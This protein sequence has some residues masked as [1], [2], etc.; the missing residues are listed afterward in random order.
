MYSYGGKLYEKNGSLSSA[1]KR[2]KPL[3]TNEPIIKPISPQKVW[4]ISEC[5]F[6]GED[7]IVAICASGKIAEQQLLKY[8]EYIL[9]DADEYLGDKD[10]IDEVVELNAARNYLLRKPLEDMDVGSGVFANKFG[11]RVYDLITNY[12]EDWK[13][14]CE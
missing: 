13:Y 6:T 11:I 5:Y 8:F 1:L 4:I 10:F 2:V 14:D 3:Q 9:A 7:H 12:E